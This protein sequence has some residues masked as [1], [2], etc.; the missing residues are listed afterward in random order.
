MRPMVRDFLTGLIAL[1][2]I[3]GLILMLFLFKEFSAPGENFIR[4][5]VQIANAGGVDSPA[6]VLLNG[7]RVGQVE[8]AAVITGGAVL[9]VRIRSSVQLPKRAVVAAERGLVGDSSLEFVIPATLTAAELA[10]VV[11][12]RSI[13]P[14]FTFDGGEG[15]RSLTSRVEA[16]VKEPIAKLESTA[17]K[18]EE[19]A[20]TYKT[21][22]ERLTEMVEP[23]TLADVE[24]GKQPNLRTAVERADRAL[25][26]AE[27]WLNDEALYTRVRSAVEKADGVLAQAE[28]LVQ[29]WKDTGKNVGDEVTKTRAGVEEFLKKA[30]DSLAGAKSAADSIA[31]IL[32]RV[33]KGEG[34]AGQLV[35][36]PDLYNSIKA[37]ADRLDLTLA[38]I[39]MLAEQYRKEGLP[40]KIGG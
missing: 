3:G 14:D 30:D 12:D 27:K 19:L 34:T 36:N 40:I 2:G 28:S 38:E 10:D 17:G 22:G 33:N 5:H 24:A 20:A 11:K 13:E 31:A 26:A 6:P 23:R 25:A 8:D 35:V 16:L 18:I 39:Q 37:A 32:E 15:A 4:F 29:T 7:V 1:V 9:S 21:L